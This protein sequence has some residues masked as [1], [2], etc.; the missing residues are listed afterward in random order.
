MSFQIHT[1]GFFNGLK[2]KTNMKSKLL[3]AVV[4]AAIM[5]IPQPA[6]AQYNASESSPRLTDPKL[7]QMGFDSRV[8]VLTSFLKQYDSPLTPYASDFVRNADKYNLDY[9]LVVAISGVESTFGKEV[10][11]ASYNAWGWGVY[12]NN[13]I[14]FSSWD[15]GIATISQGLRERY[16]GQWGGKD[17]YEIGAMYASSKAWAGHVV[18]YMDKIQEFALRSP[19]D[20]LSISL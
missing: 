8:K 13:V 7:Q 4:A 14:R 19:Q 5:L 15:E 17:I 3:L 16:M 12:G 11:P 6:Y 18:N 20:A 2:A 10:P 9:K 1:L